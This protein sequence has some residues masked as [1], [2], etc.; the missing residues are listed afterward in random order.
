M[1]FFVRPAEYPHLAR[2]PDDF[3]E[4]LSTSGSVNEIDVTIPP[5]QQ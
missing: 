3:D 4:P 5:Q 2:R 1:R